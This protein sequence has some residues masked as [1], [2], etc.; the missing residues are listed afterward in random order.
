VIP[1]GSISFFDNAVIIFPEKKKYFLY[2]QAYLQVQPYFFH[3]IINILLIWRHWLK[4]I[5]IIS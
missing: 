4:S 2:F 5:I 3:V 1:V